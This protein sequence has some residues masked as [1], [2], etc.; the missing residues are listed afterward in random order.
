MVRLTRQRN[1]MAF[2][3]QTLLHRFFQIRLIKSACLPVILF[4]YCAAFGAEIE[5]GQEI[6]IEAD[7]VVVDIKNK[8][9]VLKGNV[10]LSFGSMRLSAQKV[11]LV[12]Q[13]EG[14]QFSAYKGQKGQVLF[15]DKKKNDE[16]KGKAD[17][18]TIDQ[19][20]GKATLSKKACIFYQEDKICGATITYDMR[21]GNFLVN[22]DRSAP[23]NRVRAVIRLR[24]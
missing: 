15:S 11:E 8:Q 22:S 12:E 2:S 24:Q 10:A 7:T 3:E 17:L 1:K 5:Q 6:K 9:Q 16:I 21:D 4:T 14:Y 18:I 20:T 13:P 19:Q 23:K